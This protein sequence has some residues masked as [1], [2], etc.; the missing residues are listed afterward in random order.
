MRDRILYISTKNGSQ[1]KLRLTQSEADYFN[2]ERGAREKSKLIDTSNMD[3]PQKEVVDN[4]LSLKK[5]Q[6]ES[7]SPVDLQ[8]A[9]D[10]IESLHDN[11][12]NVVL[13][14]DIYQKAITNED[15]AKIATQVEESTDNL[16]GKNEKE[17]QNAVD[18]L[19]AEAWEG[20][21][22]LNKGENRGSIYNTFNNAFKKI[23][24]YQKDVR[25]EEHTSELQSH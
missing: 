3:A 8:N 12:E 17:I 20:Q 24:S 16:K 13:L 21:L 7:L 23:Y 18:V 15:A 10:V 2:S 25:S 5:E 22:G 19:G 6:L 11:P 1:L 14:N 4:F 9:K